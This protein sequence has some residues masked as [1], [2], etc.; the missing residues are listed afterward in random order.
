MLPEPLDNKHSTD[1]VDHVMARIEKE[2]Q[3]SRWYFVLR[4]ILAITTLSLCILVLIYVVALGFFLYRVVGGWY[5]PMR[6]WRELLDFLIA[7]PWLIVFVAGVLSTIV[8]S[9]MRRYAIVFRFP[10]LFGLGLIVV[11]AAIGG[12]F[13]ERGL[14][15]IRLAHDTLPYEAKWIKPYTPA[16]VHIGTVVRS[17]ERFVEAETL[18]GEIWYAELVNES[19][20]MP[21]LLRGE[22]VWVYGEKDK[23]YIRATYIRS[24]EDDIYWDGIHD[25]K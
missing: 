7:A 16:R 8:L 19:E 1:F 20:Q 13:T 23:N 18:E 9:R 15:K 5:I 6:G 21:I 4:S 2:Q 25:K 17:G 12:Y 11:G 24:I 10:V 3:K 22:T 14:T